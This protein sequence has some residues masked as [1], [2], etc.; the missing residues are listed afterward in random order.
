MTFG[1][2]KG[3]RFT[4]NTIREYEEATGIALTA[5]QRKAVNYTI[6]LINNTTD[7]VA[8]QKILDAVD[9][10]VA[11][12]DRIVKQFPEELQGQA[13]ELFTLSFAQSSALSPMAALHALPVTNI[14]ARNL[15]GYDAGARQN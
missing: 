9:D 10:Y 4:D 5:E 8:R 2:Y 7:P 15:K 13:K 12:E 6:R 3:F 11:L 1:K 14:D